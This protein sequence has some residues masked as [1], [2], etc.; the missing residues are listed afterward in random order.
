MWRFL[1]SLFRYSHPLDAANLSD[2]ARDIVFRVME[3]DDIS[4]CM[5]FYRANEAAHFPPGLAARYEA[6]LRGREFLTLMAMR[7]DQ[8]VGCC[9]IHHTTSIEGIPVACF[10]FG[11]ITPVHQ[12]TGVGTAQVLVRL[13]L[14]STTDDVAVAAMWA[15]PG[16]VS[17]YRRFGFDFSSEMPAA[18]GNTYPFGLLKV[19]QSFIDDC[20]V[21]LAR[22][23]IIYPDVRA[24][25]PDRKPG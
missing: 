18:D 14:L 3:E 23:N 9:G 15:V 4:T 13:A 6:K 17:F 20:R 2:K 21:I 16:S 10:C 19:S 12:R 22:R 11:M 1:R 8:P 7:N 25:I 5:S 24:S